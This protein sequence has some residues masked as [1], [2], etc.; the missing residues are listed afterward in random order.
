MV[1]S[2]WQL[3]IMVVLIITLPFVAFRLHWVQKSIKTKAVV[4]YNKQVRLSRSGNHLLPVFQY[5]AKD[6]LVTASE[7]YNLPYKEG[8][9]VNIRYN[10]SKLTHF[11]IDSFWGCWKD[12]IY[13]FTP[14]LLFV[15]MIFSAKDIFPKMI[16]IISKKSSVEA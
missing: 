9:T 4:L 10:P 14:V 16:K 3:Y 5:S 12:L 13:V 8:D 7:S 2:K 1:I 6:Y 11:R 15:T